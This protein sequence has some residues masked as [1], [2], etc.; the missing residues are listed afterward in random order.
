MQSGSVRTTQVRLYIST[1]DSRFHLNPAAFAVPAA[2]QLG[3]LGKGSVRGKAI[4]N[5]DFS[6]AKNWRF[7]ERYGF[8]FRTE[9]FNLFNHPNFVGFSTNIQNGDFGQLL[10]TQSSREIQLGFKFTF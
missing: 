5:F 4:T 3:T 1:G 10:N 7:K 2:G 8:Q 6:L 9:F